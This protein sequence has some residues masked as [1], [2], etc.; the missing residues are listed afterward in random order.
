MSGQR[1]SEITRRELFVAAAALAGGAP[2]RAE[3][4]SAAAPPAVPT[5]VLGRTGKRVSR[6]G[7]GGSWDIEPGVLA[8]GVDRGINYFDTAEGYGSGM[9]ERAMGAFIAANC[10]REQ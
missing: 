7:F 3:A 9:S 1:P 8:A 6:L 5:T 4:S 2:A 10:R